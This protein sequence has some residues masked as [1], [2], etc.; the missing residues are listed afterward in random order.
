MFRVII[1]RFYVVD[2][3]KKI[4]STVLFKFGPFQNADWT[5][6][7]FEE[8]LY[9]VNWWF[10]T[11]QKRPNMQCYLPKCWIIL[12]KQLLWDDQTPKKL[13]P[14]HF[15]ASDRYQIWSKI[16]EEWPKI[17]KNNPKLTENDLKLT[18]KC[19]KKSYFSNI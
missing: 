1:E 3:Y 4:K 18:K 12:L 13:L 9:S 15:L 11:C 7:I 16:Y 17:T 14:Y 6:H 19:L 2:S 8:L 10:D 5:A